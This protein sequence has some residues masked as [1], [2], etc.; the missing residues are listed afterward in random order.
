MRRIYVF[1]SAISAALAAAAVLT[2][3][4][5]SQ[6][7]RQESPRLVNVS[8]P[9]ANIAV[10]TLGASQAAELRGS[11]IGADHI[12]LLATR[13]GLRFYTAQSD[14]GQPCFLTS[15]DAF[16]AREFNVVACLGDGSSAVPND[17]KPLVDFS[18][19]IKRP[20]E[21]LMRIQRLAG[22][23][24]DQIRKVGIIDE[25]GS[26]H[27]VPVVANV[28]ATDVLEDTPA[29]YIVAFD[30]R[31]KEVYRHRLMFPVSG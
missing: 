27:T 26:V 5:L 24:A 8:N 30:A 13:E 11:G 15:N 22:F 17:S 14:K 16:N 25:G 7:G 2:G 19:A 4:A 3:V 10:A 1:Y 29:R 18:A 31:G 28:Y 9:G 12:R 20:Q 23:A 6:L 21:S